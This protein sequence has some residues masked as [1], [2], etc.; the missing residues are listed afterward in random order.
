MSDSTSR[1][2]RNV[3]SVGGVVIGPNGMLLVKMAY[4]ST[5][6]QYMLPGGIVDPGETLDDAVVREV[7]EETGVTAKPLG[8]CGV[9]TRCDGLDNDTYVMFLLEPVS[10]EPR[11]DG[12][13]NTDARYFSL[14]ELD[15]IDVTEL[16]RSMGKKA[17]LGQL[18]RLNFANDWDWERSGRD[19]KVWR[20][21]R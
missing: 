9:R 6:G 4:G 8:I 12:R 20:L 19:P 7:L 11:S 1:P 13:E 18:Q 14:E 10:G 2:P 17:M 15:C 3:T 16:S 5:K 21:F